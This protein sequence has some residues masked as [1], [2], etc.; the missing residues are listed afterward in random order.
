MMRRMLSAHL[1]RMPIGMV[2]NDLRTARTLVAVVVPA[3]FYGYKCN[4]P[5]PFN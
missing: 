2:S 4:P 5:L 3:F 1:M